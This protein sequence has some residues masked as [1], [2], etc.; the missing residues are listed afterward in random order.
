MP[1]AP[2]ENSFT[3][4]LIRGKFYL[5]KFSSDSVKNN[6]W[7]DSS[8]YFMQKA[9]K[10]NGNSFE[11]FFYTGI[12]AFYRG[13]LKKAAELFEKS[14]ALQNDFTNAHLYAAEVYKTLHEQ[15]SRKP[16]LLRLVHHLEILNAQTPGNPN[17]IW[18]L[19]IAYYKQGNCSDA[20]SLLYESL[21]YDR[22][23]PAEDIA[24]AKQYID[25][26]NNK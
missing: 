20:V 24:L 12:V 21:K 19:G 25:E 3:D 9:C 7:L 14:C 5:Q 10:L 18:N 4:M 1:A 8:D 26:C 23:L 15:S 2:D 16:D 13:Y 6:L 22:M 17:V 11:P